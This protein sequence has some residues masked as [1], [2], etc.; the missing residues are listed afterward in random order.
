MAERKRHRSLAGAGLMLAL[1]V[2]ALCLTILADPAPGLA[3]QALG[4][5]R[6]SPPRSFCP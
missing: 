3:A 2:L 4:R 6:P 1:S 5:H